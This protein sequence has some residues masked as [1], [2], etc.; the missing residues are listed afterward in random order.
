MR[1]RRRR[2]VVVGARRS[3][4]NLRSCCNQRCG[5][6]RG[7]GRRW[8]VI[9]PIRCAVVIL[10]DQCSRQRRRRRRLCRRP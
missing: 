4:K 6:G 9:A 1:R 8:G 3:L 5:R 2:H 10:A 7:R